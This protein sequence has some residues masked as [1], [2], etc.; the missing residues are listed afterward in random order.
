[1]NCQNVNTSKNLNV[2]LNDFPSALIRRTVF[3]FLFASILRRQRA[4][5]SHNLFSILFM[6]HFRPLFLLLSFHLSLSAVH[7]VCRFIFIFYSL[8]I[9]TIWRAV[10]DFEQIR[11][12]FVYVWTCGS[13][14]IGI[15]I[16]VQTEPEFVV[17]TQSKVRMGAA[18]VPCPVDISLSLSLSLCC[19]LMTAKLAT[20]STPQLRFNSI[21]QTEINW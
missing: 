2:N 19:C 9:F 18:F 11:W 14:R 17:D 13:A 4:Q 1:M 16:A 20:N 10:F 7:M 12:S 6:Y 15:N 5:S 8:F 3:F 21:Y